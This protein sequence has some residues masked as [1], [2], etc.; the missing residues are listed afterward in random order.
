M[1]SG[2]VEIMSGFKLIRRMLLIRSS[3]EQKKASVTA[4]YVNHRDDRAQHPV[5]F[6]SFYA[7]HGGT[8]EPAFPL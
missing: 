3:V 1:I 2:F 4:L 8:A 5:P 6:F 7:I